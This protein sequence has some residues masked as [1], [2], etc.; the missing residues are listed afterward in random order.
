MHLYG[1]PHKFTK[2]IIAQGEKKKTFTESSWWHNAS[3]CLQTV[4]FN[5]SYQRLLFYIFA[6][7]N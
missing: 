5:L 3:E 6:N 1:S 4:L 7:I 2:C